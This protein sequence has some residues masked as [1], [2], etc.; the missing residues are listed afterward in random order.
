MAWIGILNVKEASLQPLFERRGEWSSPLCQHFLFVT[1]HVGDVFLTHGHVVLHVEIVVDGTEREGLLLF[2]ECQTFKPLAF[3]LIPAQDVERFEEGLQQTLLGGTRTD[4]VS[5]D[6]IDGGIEVV[7]P[8]MGAV[9]GVGPDKLVE[10]V[11]ELEVNENEQLLD[12]LEA[13]KALGYK[14]AELNSI[15]K[16]LG[17]LEAITSDQYIRKGLGILAKRKGV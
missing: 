16:E 12:A 1:L 8:H 2:K 13:L 3:I 4:D 7:E 10:E 15:K 5:T 14:N 6:A 11:T 9:E 17:T